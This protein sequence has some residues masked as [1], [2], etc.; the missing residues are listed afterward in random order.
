M[1]EGVLHVVSVSGGKDS[2]ATLCYA[3]ETQPI[4]SVRAVFADTGNEHGLV[5]E[6][7]DYLQFWLNIKIVR[8]RRDFTPEWLHR[9]EWLRSD[10]PRTDRKDRKAYTEAQIAK[11]QAVFDREPTGNSYLDLCIIKG[12]FP[13]RRAQFCTKFLKTEPLVEYQMGL[14]D[15]GECAAVWSWQ[16]IRR[17]EGGRRQWAKEFEEVGGGLYVSR[18][19]VRWTAADCFAAMEAYGIEPNPLYSLGFDRVGCMPCINSGKADILNMAKRFP[20]HVA[21]L[22]EWEAAVVEASWQGRASFFPAPEDGRADR[23]GRNIAQVVQWSR[24][25]RG[26]RSVDLLADAP[27]E[28]CSSS[29]GL[30]E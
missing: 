2:T 19:I 8:L 21:R 16:G 13:S 7:L 23:V 20:E 11:V 25:S 1:G 30:C 17:D 12:R 10:A 9:R 18:P 24:T 14:I 5:Y 29:Y 4:E 28:A 26:G 6:Y 22:A 3:L 27:P 15:S